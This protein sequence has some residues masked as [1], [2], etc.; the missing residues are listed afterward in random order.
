[1]K[2]LKMVFAAMVFS[3]TVCLFFTADV[4]AAAPE[5]KEILV[6]VA[7]EVIVG[8]EITSTD[9]EFKDEDIIVDEN[10]EADTE[11]PEN[12]IEETP[13]KVDGEDA[14]ANENTGDE[15][16]DEIMDETSEEDVEEGTIIEGTEPENEEDTSEVVGEPVDETETDEDKT[17]SAQEP[18]K[19]LDEDV[20]VDANPD[21][22][23]NVE[24]DDSIDDTESDMS[25]DTTTD[26]EE[27]EES[28]PPEEDDTEKVVD[29]EVNVPEDNTITEVIDEAPTDVELPK[30]DVPEDEEAVDNTESTM[31]GNSNTPYFKMD[32]GDIAYCVESDKSH[33]TDGTDYE[34]NTSE[35]TQTNYDFLKDVFVNKNTLEKEGVDT[36]LL[37]KVV[38]QVIWAKIDNPDYYRT[39]TQVWLGDE[40]VALFDRL[41]ADVDTSGYNVFFTEY[42]TNSLDLLGNRFQT[43]LSAYVEGIP[44][45]PEQPEEPTDPPVVPSEPEIPET[46]DVPSQPEQPETP[47]VPKVP[48]PKNETPNHENTVPT[49]TRPTAE[50]GF[51][52]MEVVSSPQTGDTAPAAIFMAVGIIS[53]LM[54]AVVIRK[55]NVQ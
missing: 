38:Q 50:K 53:L 21:N 41:M 24:D 12:I 5:D 32:N 10:A 16:S 23:T 45:Q 36:D 2:N 43:L 13:G 30:A 1:M 51:L 25:E 9:Q 31:V 34:S 28:F 44:Q 26:R 46:P 22:E 6:E 39:N 20:I 42:I 19:N 7:D 35:Q 15:T 17:D 40:A 11:E 29:D 37:N 48:E 55:M 27:D 33:P 4:N 54:L 14:S 49:A 18:E 8:S 3:L 52:S 47:H